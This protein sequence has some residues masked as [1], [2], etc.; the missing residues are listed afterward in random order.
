[1]RE[2]V[3]V[4]NTIGRTTAVLKIPIKRPLPFTFNCQCVYIVSDV[5]AN[6]TQRIVTFP[7]L[8]WLRERS[9]VLR[10]FTL[11][12]RLIKQN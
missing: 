6:S 2:L 7:L 1:M 11:P 3:G 4:K 10:I 12:P 5:L 9:T 8:Q